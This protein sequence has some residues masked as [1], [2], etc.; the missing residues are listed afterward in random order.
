MVHLHL[1]QSKP[2]PAS[3]GQVI[4]EARKTMPMEHSW[5][6]GFSGFSAPSGWVVGLRGWHW[7]L[8]LAD[9]L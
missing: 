3:L 6:R 4:L 8:P 9:R 7:L 5:A 1:P 2:W